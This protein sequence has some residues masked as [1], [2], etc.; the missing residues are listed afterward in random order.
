MSILTA[1]KSRRAKKSSRKKSARTPRRLQFEGLEQKQLMAVD[2]SL[3]ASGVLEVEAGSTGAYVDISD[4]YTAEYRSGP[5]APWLGSPLVV[6]HELFVTTDDAS[7]PVQVKR[8]NFND[9]K[10]IRFIGSEFS[11]KVGNKTS[12]PMTAFGRGGHD[13][14]AGGSG[15]DHID[16]GRGADLLYGRAGS[17]TLIGGYGNDQLY[18]ADGHDRLYGGCDDDKLYGGRGNDL[19]DAYS[20]NDLLDGGEG[21]DTLYG[22][23]GADQLDG[24]EGNDFLGGGSGNDELFG[25]AGNDRLYGGADDDEM[26][27]GRGDDYLNAYLGND[28]LDGGEGTDRLYGGEGIDVLR[29]G[30]G[31]DILHGGNGNDRLFG[32][33]GSDW[34]YGEQGNDGLFGGVPH[35]NDYDHIYGGAGNDRFLMHSRES[36]DRCDDNSHDIGLWFKDDSDKWTN[37]EIEVVD[38]AFAELQEKADGRQWILRDSFTDDAL[39]FYKAADTGQKWDGQNYWWWQPFE[40]NRKIYIKDWKEFDDGANRQAR[41]TVIH[42]IGHNWDDTWGEDN[43][44]MDAFEDLHDMSF[45]I[46]DFARNYGMEDAKEDWCTCWEVY[47]GYTGLVNPSPILTAKLAIVDAFFDYMS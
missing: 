25:G 34:L 45:S 43:P 47:F 41:S 33:H 32:E 15:D 37:R 22:G 7:Q 2:L 24:G 23:S 19:L 42:E 20:G 29:G 5:W 39:T 21:G 30:D 4:G 1:L 17:D 46:N 27:G 18:G 3:G 10:E 26:L 31:N 35:G 38:Q 16:G 40:F 36:A 11:D 12:I 14:I 13:I 44:Y 28:L 8:F 6:K 9:V